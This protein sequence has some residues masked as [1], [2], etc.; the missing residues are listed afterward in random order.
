MAYKP[1]DI[2]QV[3]ND[4]ELFAVGESWAVVHV[5]RAVPYIGRIMPDS[6]DKVVTVLKKAIAREI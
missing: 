5:M 4:D 6:M 1:S 3:L 2:K